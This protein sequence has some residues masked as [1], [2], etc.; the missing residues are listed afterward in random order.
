M[1]GELLRAERVLVR[2]IPE[3]PASGVMVASDAW[4]WMGGGLALRL[5]SVQREAL[6]QTFLRL[7]WHEA[8]EEA[9]SGSREFSW[10]RA[11]ERPFDVPEV[12]GSASVRWEPSDARLEADSRALA[13]HVINGRPPAK[14]APRLWFPAG[15][16]HHDQL[17]QLADA[18]VEVVWS[19]RGLPDIQVSSGGGEVLLPGTRGRLRLRLTAP[20]AQ[21]LAQLLRAPSAWRFSTRVRLGDANHRQ[22]RFWL[23]GEQASRGLEDEQHI[24][25]PPVQASS[26]RTVLETTPSTL[27]P[28]QPLAL[29]VCYQ[30]TVLPP[31]V[32][33][34]AEEDALVRSWR[35]VDE[36][37]ATRLAKVREALTAAEGERGRLGGAF[38]RLVS[39]MLGFQ[40]TE[41]GLLAQAEVLAAQRPSEA[42][43]ADAPALLSHLGELE[44]GAR[45]LQL[46]LEEAERKA[47][48]D[49]E[50]DRQRD[51]WQARVDTAQ[52]ELPNRREA[53]EE[54]EG[55]RNHIAEQLRELEEGLR[56]ASKEARR[57]LT[58]NQ[59]RL[60]DELT[61]VNREIGRLRGE[62]AAM[63]Q[64]A[65][66]P[67]EFRPAPSAPRRSQ[68]GGRFVP[69]A[70]SARPQTS[71]PTEALPE[72]G[73][74]RR[75]KGERFL[76]IE[77]WSELEAGE[78][79]A[80]RLSAAL[81]G[82][83]D[84]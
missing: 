50:R 26:L 64:T 31:R 32:P 68:T 1:D 67:F 49:E 54:A 41:S 8:T 40:R 70:A 37:W 2:R 25:L 38:S 43:P 5:D 80:T 22:A 10:R 60:S 51:A 6:R 74:L 53:V 72:V 61:R 35:T 36:H 16:D 12:P 77:T 55:R 47:R 63:E 3:V 27:P 18:G 62:V 76:V 66:E 4:V 56:A 7:F 52:R 17:G 71:V 73:A 20:Q 48:E 33:T 13:L 44:E 65:A 79:E 58:A 34:G 82:P 46:D 11:S 28:A 45:K 19:D 42:G 78:R 83:E 69:Q 15:A 57:D 9:W 59:R 29:A 14:A 81:V 30:W 39:A 84:A 23:S 24:E 75:H 21:E